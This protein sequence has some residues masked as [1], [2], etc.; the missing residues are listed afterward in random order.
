MLDQSNPLQY[1][2]SITEFIENLKDSGS[3]LINFFETSSCFD[4]TPPY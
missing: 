4:L 1:S 2:L 3:N